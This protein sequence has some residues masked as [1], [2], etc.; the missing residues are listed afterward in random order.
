MFST[1]HITY[2]YEGCTQRWAVGTLKVPSVTVLVLSKKCTDGSGI[3][4][5]FKK[6][7]RYIVGTGTF[8]VKDAAANAIFTAI[9]PR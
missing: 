3:Q 4:Y 5:C 2:M 8:R 7:V 6:V 1:F 9:M